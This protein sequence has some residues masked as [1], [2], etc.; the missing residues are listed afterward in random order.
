M[1]I[2]VDPSLATLAQEHL[3]KRTVTEV[4]WCLNW[5]LSLYIQAPAGAHFL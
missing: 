5:S 2:S 4:C 1:A 3:K